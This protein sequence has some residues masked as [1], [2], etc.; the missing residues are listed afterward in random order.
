ML[1]N[2]AGSLRALGPLWE[3]AARR[4]VGGRNTSLGG[5]FNLCRE[6]V[7]RMIERR[8]GRIVNVTSYVGVRPSPYQTGYACG[9]AALVALT[10]ALAASLE[11]HAIAVVLR[12]ARVHARPR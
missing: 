8:A 1:V 3:V 2:N 7:P 12:R 6:V 11:Q 5:A 4:L 10:E 9:K